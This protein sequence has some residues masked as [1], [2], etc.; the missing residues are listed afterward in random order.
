MQC[1]ENLFCRFFGVDVSGQEEAFRFKEL[2][3]RLSSL[4]GVIIIG[5]YIP[6]LKWTTVVT[7]FDKYM[8]KVKADLDDMLQEFLEVKKNGKL[9]MNNE[10]QNYD[11]TTPATAANKNQNHPDDFVDILLR[12]P[13]EDGTGHLADSSIKAV[14]QVK[15]KHTK[16]SDLSVYSSWI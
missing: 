2:N 15:T 5:D 16:Q 11:S 4:A 13:A 12:Q 7:G 9:C 8:K 1:D 3:T 6:W 14:I 10:L